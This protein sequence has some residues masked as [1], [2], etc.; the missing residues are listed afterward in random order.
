MGRVFGIACLYDYL[1][2]IENEYDELILLPSG[3]SQLMG[4]LEE[5]MRLG[6]FFFLNPPF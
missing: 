6:S 2:G 3:I 4:R 5:I 1:L